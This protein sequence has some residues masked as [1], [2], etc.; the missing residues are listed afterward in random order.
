MELSKSPGR[1]I[2]TSQDLN[3]ARLSALPEQAIIDGFRGVIDFYLCNGIPCARMWP[4][5]K[6]RDPTP[7]ERAAQERFA[8]VNKMISQLPDNIR[9]LYRDMVAGTNYRWNDLAVKI[10]LSGIP[11][12]EEPELSW[13]E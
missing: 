6:T 5:Y 13:H 8:Y 1:G 7:A 3:M 11:T 4:R 10:Y 9:Q 12:W 2:K